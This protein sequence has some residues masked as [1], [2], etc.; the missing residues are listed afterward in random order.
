MAGV[1]PGSP[2]TGNGLGA[3]TWQASVGE[4]ASL[5]PSLALANAAIVCDRL[6]RRAWTGYRWE[7]RPRRRP[8]PAC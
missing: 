2:S 8:E 7:G 6:V 4:A 1:A 3:R 5:P